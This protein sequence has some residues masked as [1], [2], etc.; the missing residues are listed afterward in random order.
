MVTSLSQ[1]HI[2]SAASIDMFS[3]S[4]SQPITSS[5]SSLSTCSQLVSPPAKPSLAKFPKVSS[6]R[7]FLSYFAEQGA[8]LTEEDLLIFDFTGTLSEEIKNPESLA[9]IQELLKGGFPVIVCTSEADRDPLLRRLES[10]HLSLTSRMGDVEIPGGILT[11]FNKGVEI[12]KLLER[13]PS[14]KGR[15]VLID[16]T[17]T[18]LFMAQLFLN[19]RTAERGSAVSFVPFLYENPKTSEPVTSPS[20]ISPVKNPEEG[21]KKAKAS[22]LSIFFRCCGRS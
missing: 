8:P 15:V 22:C 17:V 11:A 21:P 4:S 18:N 10:C 20:I 2:A 9:L 3:P 7:E 16:D 12:W 14:F 6:T 5:P 13:L 1:I 19:K